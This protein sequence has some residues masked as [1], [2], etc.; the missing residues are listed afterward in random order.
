[1]PSYLEIFVNNLSRLMDERGLNK[2]DMARL[3]G[4]SSATITT[5]INGK[6]LNPSLDIMQG[7]AKGFGIP[8]PLMLKPVESE[9]WQTA[10]AVVNSR[11][12]AAEQN[13]LPGYAIVDVTVLTESQAAEVDRWAREIQTRLNNLPNSSN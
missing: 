6:T 12:T 8:L 11:R 5:L 13:L 7:I 1:M 2:R 10:L 3:S 9:E 4:V